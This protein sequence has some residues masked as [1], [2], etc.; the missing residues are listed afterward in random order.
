LAEP[1]IVPATSPFDVDATTDLD[2]PSHQNR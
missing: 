2:L 1:S